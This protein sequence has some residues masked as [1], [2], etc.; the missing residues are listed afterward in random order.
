MASVKRERPVG[1]EEPEKGGD[2]LDL[3]QFIS[4][5][6]EMEV[7]EEDEDGL[8]RG[9]APF[10]AQSSSCDLTEEEEPHAWS[11]QQQRQRSPAAAVAPRPARWM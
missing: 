6:A 4:Q 9:A 11:G 7:V 5:E 3:D 2:P 1:L 10:S 8:R